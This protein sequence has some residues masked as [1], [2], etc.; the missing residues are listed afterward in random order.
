MLVVLQQCSSCKDY[1]NTN[2][3]T[4]SGGCNSIPFILLLDSPKGD[5][6]TDEYDWGLITATPTQPSE[7]CGPI[8]TNDET[9]P[10]VI[11]LGILLQTST[12]FNRWSTLSKQR[13][14]LSG[15]FTYQ[16]DCW[17]YRIATF[18]LSEDLILR[19]QFLRVFWYHWYCHLQG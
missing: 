5:Q 15:E 13:Y 2:L 17:G 19:L 14:I 7:D 10:K 1:E 16:T 6:R 4:I 8:N 11:E 12:T 3:F 9:I 18:L